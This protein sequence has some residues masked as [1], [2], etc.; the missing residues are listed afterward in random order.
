MEEQPQNTEKID[1]E[2]RKTREEIQSWELKQ[3]KQSSILDRGTEKRDY[4][5]VTYG[6]KHRTARRKQRGRGKGR[7]WQGRE[8]V[9]DEGRT[10]DHRCGH[11][12]GAGVALARGVQRRY[13]IAFNGSKGKILI[14]FL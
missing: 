12:G 8:D 7:R 13:C 10:P 2:I 4:C 3:W 5:L 1:K 11:Q 6:I 14:C 9:H